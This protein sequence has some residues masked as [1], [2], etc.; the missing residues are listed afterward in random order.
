MGEDAQCAS[1]LHREIDW[2]N[3]NHQTTKFSESAVNRKRGCGII[4]LV[5]GIGKLF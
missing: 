4:Q 5:F 3:I 2:L 1:L